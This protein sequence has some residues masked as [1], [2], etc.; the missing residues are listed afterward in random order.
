MFSHHTRERAIIGV[1]IEIQRKRRR[2]KN[3]NVIRRLFEYKNICVYPAICAKMDDDISLDH[4][5]GFVVNIMEYH[6]APVS[7]LFQISEK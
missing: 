4:L 3:A 1:I 6:S 2:V 5:E 7:D